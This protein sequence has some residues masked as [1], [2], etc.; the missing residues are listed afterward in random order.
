MRTP[1]ETAIDGH[2]PGTGSLVAQA[3]RALVRGATTHALALARQA[4]TANPDDA[5]AWLTLGAACQSSG[6]TAG[7]R[8]AY[9]NCVARAHTPN[10]SECRLLLRP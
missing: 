9:R 2:D 4:V 10:I 7:A 5:D 1:Q 6:D 8:D 3:N